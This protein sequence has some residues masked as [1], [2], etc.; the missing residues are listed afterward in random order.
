MTPR[1]RKYHNRKRDYKYGKTLAQL[2]WIT[3]RGLR[4]NAPKY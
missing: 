2:V 1:E 4:V 3:Y